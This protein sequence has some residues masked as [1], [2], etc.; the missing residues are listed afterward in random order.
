MLHPFVSVVTALNYDFNPIVTKIL[1][2]F[3]PKKF[4]AAIPHILN[5]TIP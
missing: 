3:I 5:V 4:N 1:I 2:I